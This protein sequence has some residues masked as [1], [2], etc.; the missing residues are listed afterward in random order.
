MFLKRWETLIRFYFL[1]LFLRKQ[2]DVSQKMG[3]V[4]SFFFFVLISEETE[5]CFSK[6]GR[7]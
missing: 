5:R 4:D 1:F 3:D 2:K 7:R 6:D